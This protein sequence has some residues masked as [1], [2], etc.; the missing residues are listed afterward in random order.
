MSLSAMDKGKAV[1]AYEGGQEATVEGSI[2]FLG[3]DF[4][5]AISHAAVG[6]QGANSQSCPYQFQGVDCKLQV[7]GL[8]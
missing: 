5:K 4:G 2:P 7:K 8:H 3:N 1:E 6:A